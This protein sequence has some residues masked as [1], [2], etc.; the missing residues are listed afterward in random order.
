MND[1]LDQQRFDPILQIENSQTVRTLL[2]E[3][4]SGLSNYWKIAD[5]IL[6]QSD[7]RLKVQGEDGFSL[8]KNFFSF[9]FLYSFYRAGIPKSRRILYAA[10]LQCLRAWSPDV[11]TF[12][13]M[14]IKRRWTP[15]SR[16]LP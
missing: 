10:T 8:E 12:W 14:N 11:T 3:L 1:D 15:T 5:G 6:R 2:D 9:L 7:I 13:M 4:R 16:K